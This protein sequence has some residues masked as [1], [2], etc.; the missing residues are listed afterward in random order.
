[1]FVNEWKLYLSVY[2]LSYKLME[3]TVKCVLNNIKPL[4]YLIVD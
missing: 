3:D 4:G 1:M 2:V